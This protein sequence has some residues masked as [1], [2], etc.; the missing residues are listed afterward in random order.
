MIPPPYGIDSRKHH[1]SDVLSAWL[2][3]DTVTLWVSA[4]LRRLL[5]AEPGN[6]GNDVQLARR[7]RI[8]IRPL[9]ASRQPRVGERPLWTDHIA[10]AALRLYNDLQRHPN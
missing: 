6:R 7:P 8:P 10:G 5:S 1:L 9:L 4:S 2:H 3:A